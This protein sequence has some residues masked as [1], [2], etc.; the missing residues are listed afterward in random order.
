MENNQFYSFQSEFN[1]DGNFFCF[2]QEIPFL[3]TISP[4]KSKLWIE[5]EIWY[6]G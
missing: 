1:S 4:K 2:R 5:A 6:L 3:G